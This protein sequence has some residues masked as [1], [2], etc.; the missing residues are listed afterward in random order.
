V[1]GQP[2]PVFPSFPLTETYVRGHA[3]ASRDEK[4]NTRTKSLRQGR[5]FIRGSLVVRIGITGAGGYYSNSG[6]MEADGKV[7]Q[8]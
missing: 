4:K 7:S 5:I 1:A 2:R 8:N 3:W 6:F